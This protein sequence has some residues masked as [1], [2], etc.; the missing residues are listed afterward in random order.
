MAKKWAHDPILVLEET[1]SYNVPRCIPHFEYAGRRY[2]S[3]T[4]DHL[5][6]FPVLPHYQHDNDPY[7]LRSLCLTDYGH[8]MGHLFAYDDAA[9]NMDRIDG[10][11]RTLKALQ[12][13]Y[14]KYEMAG[15]IVRGDIGLYLAQMCEVL[16]V[17]QF[18]YQPPADIA[19]RIREYGHLVD[20]YRIAP[21][22]NLRSIYA[23]IHQ[24]L[25]DR[26]ERNA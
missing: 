7:D 16:G 3:D 2:S 14:E 4:E 25:H 10:M 12:T 17:K 1:N 21:I 18:A 11:K 23:D 6:P 19:Q 5:I 24:S 22:A 26:L 20:G 8:D 13:G 9:V 15:Q